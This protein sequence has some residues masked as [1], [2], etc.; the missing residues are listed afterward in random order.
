MKVSSRRCMTSVGTRIE[1]ST[2]RTSNSPIRSKMRLI[3]AGLAASR[4]SRPAHS[5]K[6]GSPAG[7]A[8]RC[9]PPAPRPSARAPA[10]MFALALLG[11]PGPVV[12]GRPGGAREGRVQDQRAD[13]VRVGGGEQRGHRPA[14]ERPGDRG[15]LRAGGV[16]HG[17]HVVH[18]LLERG[19]AAERIGEPGATPVEGDHARNVVSRSIPSDW[20]VGGGVG[21]GQ[22]R[23][24]PVEGDHAGELR[25]TVHHPARATPRT[26]GTRPARSRAGSR[27]VERTVTLDDVRDVQVPAPGVAG[28]RGHAIEVTGRGYRPWP[29]PSAKHPTSSSSASRPRASSTCS[30]SRARRRST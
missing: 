11:G 21:V 23:A 9:R 6:S 8:R 28:D 26:R 12:A 5:M 10:A 15:A 30:A 2:S 4:S 17:D 19:R 16:H 24:A 22:A 13:A 7:S 1:G 29:W 3:V 14:L 25:Q 27:Q 20:R 18:L